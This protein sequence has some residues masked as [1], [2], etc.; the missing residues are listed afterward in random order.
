MPRAARVLGGSA[1]GAAVVA[2]I[3]LNHYVTAHATTIG[4]LG[5]AVAA[6]PY[7]A[8]ALTLAWWSPRRYLMLALCAAAAFLLGHY[9]ADL[10]RE[11]S[12]LYFLEHIGASVAGGLIFGRT[13]SRDREPLC[14]RFA[15]MA[16]GPLDAKVARY[17]R[18]VTVAWTLFFAA[19]A[20]LSVMLFFAAPIELWSTFANVLSLPLLGLMFGAEYAI[21]LRRLPDLKHVPLL[22]SITIYW[23][24]SRASLPPSP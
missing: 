18:Q 9:A 20:T 3:L 6:I 21:R 16:H 15:A 13:L 1:I 22:D 12:W 4:A 7:F 10:T 24:T 19:T 8:T 17:T 5:I 11:V 2:Y 23:R 14:S